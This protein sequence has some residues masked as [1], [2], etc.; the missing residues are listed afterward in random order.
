[1]YFG[2]FSRKMI[3]EC[4][5]YHDYFTNGGKLKKYTKTRG[6]KK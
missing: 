1:M 5:F 2:N 3:D 4:D 6:M